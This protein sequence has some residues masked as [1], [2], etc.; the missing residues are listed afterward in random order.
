M[1]NSTESRVLEHYGEFVAKVFDRVS[2]ATNAVSPELR[3]PVEHHLATLAQS[4]GIRPALVKAAS[5]ISKWTPTDIL[6]RAAAVQL[7]HESTLVID[8][9]LDD[10]PK[11]RGIDSVMAKYGKV[12]A[13]AVAA[14]LNA[15]ALEYIDDDWESRALSRSLMRRLCVAEAVQE[16]E[17]F[18]AR[19]VAIETWQKIE[20]G[21]TGAIFNFAL[22]LGG[23]EPA[24]YPAAEA[25]AYLRHGLDDIDDLLDET[26]DQA[27][28]RDRVPTLL[29]CFTAGETSDH[30]IAAVPAALEW[31]RP[32]LALYKSPGN[33]SRWESPM[34]PFF[35][36]FAATWQSL[37]IASK[38]H[39]Q[40][41]RIVALE[42]GL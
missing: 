7:V 11:R 30:L 3:E 4:K 42:S 18:T 9:I 5:E 34:R 41:S 14:E 10:S 39:N 28:V 2:L 21:D 29:T 40:K 33:E 37:S 32:L 35:D 24:G 36:D 12:I 1:A 22:G 19:P 38:K 20:L 23:I 16:R 17:R 13:A 27:D 31:L 26:G 8:D 6:N 25:M 15:I